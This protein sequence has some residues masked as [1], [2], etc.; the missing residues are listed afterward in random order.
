MDREGTHGRQ[1]AGK[2]VR[3]THLTIKLNA[4]LKALKLPAGITDLDAGLADVNGDDLT[5]VER[6][7][8]KQVKK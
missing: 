2:G 1:C 6:C 8:L 3:A 4:V 5:H 7:L